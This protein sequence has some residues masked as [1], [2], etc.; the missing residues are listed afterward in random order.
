MIV[1]ADTILSVCMNVSV[2]VCVFMSAMLSV[3]MNVSA[4]VGTRFA[5]ADRGCRC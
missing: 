5:E 4:S 3:C 2:S 1:S